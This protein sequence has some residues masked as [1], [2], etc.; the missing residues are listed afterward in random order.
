MLFS[1]HGQE[2]VAAVHHLAGHGGVGVDDGAQRGR[3]LG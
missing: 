1:G 3:T 2:G